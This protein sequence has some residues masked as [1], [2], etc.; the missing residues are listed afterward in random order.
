MFS[1]KGLLRVSKT[2]SKTVN[3]RG[4]L[5]SNYL[6]KIDSKKC[7][8]I[9]FSFPL[10]VTPIESQNS[11]ITDAGYPRRRKPFK[12]NIRGSSHPLT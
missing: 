12:V 8:G 2:G 7:K 3:R 5:T 11:L 6:L 4:Q 10:L 1:L 9:I